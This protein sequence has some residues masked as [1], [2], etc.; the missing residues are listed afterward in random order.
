MIL[1]RHRL[2]ACGETAAA[3]FFWMYQP[4]RPREVQV[5]TMKMGQELRYWMR[6]F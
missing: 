5:N 2:L 3:A 6:P 4:Q 1:R